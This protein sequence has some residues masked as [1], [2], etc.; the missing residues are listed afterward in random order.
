VL[1]PD[2]ALRDHLDPAVAARLLREHRKGSSTHEHRLWLLLMFE[3]WA[4]R[5]LSPAGRVA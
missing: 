4:R 1:A 2:G 3:L 5:W